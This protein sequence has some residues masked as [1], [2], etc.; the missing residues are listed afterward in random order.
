MARE[1]KHLVGN[2]FLSSTHD[3]PNVIL[4]QV[5]LSTCQKDQTKET[6]LLVIHSSGYWIWICRS[7]LWTLTNGEEVRICFWKKLTKELKD[8]IYTRD[9]IW[10]MNRY[11]WNITISLQ[12]G[13]EES[14]STKKMK[15]FARIIRRIMKLLY[16]GIFGSFH[17]PTSENYFM[18]KSGQNLT[19]KKKNRKHLFVTV[20][21]YFFFYFHFSFS[22]RSVLLLV[23]N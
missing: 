13:T 21:L 6:R 23:R 14:M 19:K 15:I 9:R 8:A 16:I 2:N 18:E 17:R 1:I 11:N 12:W 7:D 10:Q 20:F 22:I 3:L 5:I 4:K